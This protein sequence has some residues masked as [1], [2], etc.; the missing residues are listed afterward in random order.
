MDW[1]CGHGHPT[2]ANGPFPLTAPARLIAAL[3]RAHTLIGRDGKGLPTAHAAPATPYERKLVQ[4]AFLSPMIQQSILDG[5]QP[6][7]MTLS[8]LLENDI[9]LSWDEQDRIYQG[10]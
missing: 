9:P 5:D 1:S 2:S 4:L 3:K 10:V 6:A 8:S 7:G